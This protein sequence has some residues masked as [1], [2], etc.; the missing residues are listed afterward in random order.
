[1]GP[2]S[3]NL[4]NSETSD[5]FKFPKLNGSNHA[6]WVG[7][8]KYALQSKYLWLIVTG[9]EECPPE[10]TADAKEAEKRTIKRERLEWLLRDQAAM[11]NIKSAWENSQ[12]PFIE[13]DSIK[14]AKDMWEE[15][16]KVHQTNLSKINVTICSRTFIL[17][18]MS[19]ALRWMSILLAC[20]I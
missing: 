1:M 19:T 7:H 20:S 11:G 3:N 8:M 12:L 15:L 14:S 4:L 17:G 2:A 18:N 5:S 6:S 9:G 16:K 10:A 13:K